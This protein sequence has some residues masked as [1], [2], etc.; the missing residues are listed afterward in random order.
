MTA[1]QENH[2]WFHGWRRAGGSNLRAEGQPGTIPIRNRIPHHRLPG[3]CY[4]SILPLAF[5]SL[6]YLFISLQ[7]ISRGPSSLTEPSKS[8]QSLTDSK[9]CFFDGS[10]IANA[11]SEHRSIAGIYSEANLFAAKELIE[12]SCLS[13]NPLKSKLS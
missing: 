8:L 2:F 10:G 12:K 9:N 1:H 7:S 11:F 5:R 13:S 6:S 4:L 3:F